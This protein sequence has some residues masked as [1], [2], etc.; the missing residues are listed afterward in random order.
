M[1]SAPDTAR[2]AAEAGPVVVTADGGGLVP[3]VREVIGAERVVHMFTAFLKRFPKFDGRVVDV[4][5]SPG[6]VTMAADDVSVLSFTLDGGRITAINVVRNPEK[7]R[8]L[9]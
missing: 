4:N 6:A 8:A 2:A 1:T 5:G 9:P 7:L 3:A